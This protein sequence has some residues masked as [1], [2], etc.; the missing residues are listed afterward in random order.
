MPEDPEPHRLADAVL[1]LAA[2]LTLALIGAQTVA[3]AAY[4]QMAGLTG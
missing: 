1:L 3:V 4:E 2:V